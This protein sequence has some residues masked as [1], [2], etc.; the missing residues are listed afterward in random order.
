MDWDGI[1]E[2][3]LL[4]HGSSTAYFAISITTS[5]LASTTDHRSFSC[6]LYFTGP[7]TIASSLN[8]NPDKLVPM[9]EDYAPRLLP[10]RSFFFSFA[11]S[12]SFSSFLFSSFFFFST[13][14]FVW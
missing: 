2:G 12:F 14:S 4:C 6:L 8:S 5:L 1:R 9:G 13:T 11:F 10:S 3:K 7:L